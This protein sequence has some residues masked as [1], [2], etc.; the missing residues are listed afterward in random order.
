MIVSDSEKRWLVTG[1][2]INKIVAPVLRDVVKQGM[3]THYTNLDTYCSDLT[4]PCTLAMQ[5][6]HQVHADSNLR[7]LKFQ[8]INNN[9]INHGNHTSL[10]NYNVKSSVNL[11]KFIAR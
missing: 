9:L 5:T 7:R 11:A 3:D 8:N 6:Y 1:I 2:A 4:S 10:Y